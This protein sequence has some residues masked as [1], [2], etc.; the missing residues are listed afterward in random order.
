MLPCQCQFYPPEEN[1][2]REDVLN[3]IVTSVAYE[4]LALSHILNAEGEKIQ[5]AL[6]TLPGNPNDATIDDVLDVN[7]SVGSMLDTV[8]DNQMILSSKL[9]SALSATT[10]TGEPGPT[11][12]DGAQ[13]DPTGVIGPTGPQSGI[14]QTGS[15]GALGDVGSVGAVGATGGVGVQ[16]VVGEIGVIGQT[17]AVGLQGAVGERGHSDPNNPQT[18]VHGCAWSTSEKTF[19]LTA[20]TPVNALKTDETI[21]TGMTI[22]AGVIELDSTGYYLISYRLVFEEPIVA[23]TYMLDSTATIIEASFVNEHYEE[24]LLVYEKQFIVRCTGDA[25]VLLLESN[26]AITAIT[27]QNGIVFTTAKLG[28]LHLFMTPHTDYLA[29]K[30]SVDQTDLVTVT[31]NPSGQTVTWSSSDPGI[32][33]VDSD[34]NVTSIGEGTV[35]I[36]GTLATGE[37]ESYTLTTSETIALA[38]GNSHTLALKTDG[39][40]WSWGY[41]VDGQLGDGTTTNSNTPV[42]AKNLTDVISIAVGS[43]HSLALK[44]DGTVW[45]WGYN[46][47]GQLGIGTFDP[48]AHPIPTKIQGLINVTALAAGRYFSMALKSDGTVWTWGNNE[49]GQLGDGTK[50]DRSTPVQTLNMTDVTAIAAGVRHSL[51]LRADGTVWTC[52]LNN[53]GQLGIGT[54]DYGSHPIFVKTLNLIDII[55]ISSGVAHSYAIKSDDTIW[56][57]G[58]VTS[59]DGS[60]IRSPRQYS[61]SEVAYIVGGEWYTLILK[62]D[63]T[64][65]GFGSNSSGQL[66]DGTTTDRITP[67]QTLNLSDVVSI[68]AS[69]HS[70]ALKSDGSAWSWGGNLVGQLGDGTTT[71]RLI[72]VRV[73]GPNNVGWF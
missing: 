71:N 39:T 23:R 66:G 52:G 25:L 6:G 73:H 4:E 18:L 63:S 48:A 35:K 40:V 31:T 30:E 54:L 36:T 46:N 42:H 28:D 8:L 41:N 22:A 47:L 57:W 56:F 24:N 50:T 64:V 61:L 26:A 45:A 49:A 5:Y 21:S 51:A 72:P 17:G 60:E 16:G 19:N 9:T 43:Y 15:K 12:P 38:G 34:G 55:S 20:N 33:A 7:E 14:G 53:Y 27:E 11:G 3:Q 59:A 44:A 37:T 29:Y 69:T 58:G 10:F 13:G 70:L 32:I 65:W 68:S 67:V 62:D 2:S 1:F